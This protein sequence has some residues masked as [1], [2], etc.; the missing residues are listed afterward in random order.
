MGKVNKAN[1]KR[2]R[3]ARSFEQRFRNTAAGHQ[4]V[5]VERKMHRAH[6]AYQAHFVKDEGVLQLNIWQEFIIYMIWLRRGLDNDILC[7]KFLGKK[8]NAS[9]RCVR[10]VLRTWAGVVHSVLNAEEWWLK[11]EKGLCLHSKAFDRA[12]NTLVVSDCSNVN[13]GGTC[14]EMIRQQLYSSYYKHTCGKYCVSCSR[15]GGC[16]SCGPGQGGPAGD[17]QCMKASGLF[18]SEKWVVGADE[19]W[20]QHLYDAGVSRRTRS[21]CLECKCDLQTSGIVRNSA[22][23]H[24]SYQQRSQ[25]FKTSS[26]RIRVENFIGIIKQR[27]KILNQNI[28]L[29]E[30]GLL[31]KV[32]FS[33]FMLHNFGNPIIN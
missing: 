24:M 29:T 28:P 18:N 33:C 21:A 25:N 26:L 23:N 9:M 32:V 6:R 1:K 17:F 20:P 30:L 7:D 22:K 8:T 14:D 2:A 12:P 27:F 15:I 3:V 31:D 5:Q 19:P 11:A 13:V 10:E 4:P 16:V